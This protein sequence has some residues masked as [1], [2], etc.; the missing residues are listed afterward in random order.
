MIAQMSTSS[1]LERSVSETREAMDHI[2][3]SL[4]VDNGHRVAL[5][6]ELV[7]GTILVDGYAYPNLGSILHSYKDKLLSI[8]VWYRCLVAPSS[9]S[10]N[11]EPGTA[12]VHYAWQLPPKRLVTQQLELL[13]SRLVQLLQIFTD[14]TPLYNY[15]H[16]FRDS[17]RSVGFFG[18][19]SP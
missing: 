6:D 19:A 9:S 2:Q 11:A 4:E 1:V 8:P 10:Q 3:S 12:D 17:F 14:N 16:Q 13:V 15:Q 18:H 7:R 5:A